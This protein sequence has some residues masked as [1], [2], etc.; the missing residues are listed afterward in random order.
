MPPRN[1]TSAWE[2]G[3]LTW[4][5][6][7]I[8]NTV[9]SGGLPVNWA[10]PRRSIQRPFAKMLGLL[11]WH[12]CMSL[13]RT[14]IFL[15]FVQRSS[16]VAV[17]SG[18]E[19]WKAEPLQA[20]L[21]QFQDIQDGKQGSEKG[22]IAR[23]M[24]AGL[25]PLVGTAKPGDTG[26]FTMG[27]PAE[28]GPE[29]DQGDNP[30]HEVT[31]SPYRLHQFCVT[32]EEYELFD[33]RHASLRW[34]GEHPLEKKARGKKKKAAD[35]RCPVVNVSWYDA[36]CF[37]VWCGCQLPTE[38]QWEYASR[39]GRQTP[40]SFAEPHTG[41]TCS[42]EVC[43]FDSNYPFGEGMKKEKLRGHTILV[44]GLSPNRW[45]FYQMHGNVWEW[46]ADWYSGRFY[47]TKEG[48]KPDP[49]NIA[50]ASARVLR[51]GSW[52]CSGRRCRSAYRFW[53]AP[54]NRLDYFGFRLAAVP[55][56]AK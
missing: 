43:N 39:A 32:N 13:W 26:T 25:L 4:G 28:E 30:Q 7:E 36:W 24:L 22:K 34:R 27:A 42:A 35:D 15:Q 44:D 12:R 11:R 16:S 54:V 23:K 3:S 29:W 38:A 50:A 14:Q 9:S 6:I 10:I 52:Y 48:N 20:F 47:E 55:E 31:L 49:Q 56:G 21:R 2:I 40:F 37:A 33:G 18:M 17:G 8:R 41:E 46:C 51:G 45:K 19:R 5:M 53:S 1:T